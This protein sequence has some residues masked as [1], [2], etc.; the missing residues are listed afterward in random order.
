M[1]SASVT[2]AIFMVSTVIYFIARYYVV[3]R[4]I[5]GNTTN[6]VILPKYA[7]AH[8]KSDPPCY[9]PSSPTFSSWGQ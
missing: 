9:I 7:Q 1:I 3:D 2:L 4:H 5:D 8:L 6:L